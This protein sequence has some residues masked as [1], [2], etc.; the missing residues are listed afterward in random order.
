MVLLAEELNVRE[1]HHLLLFNPKLLAEELRAR[2]KTL[3]LL[4]IKKIAHLFLS[5]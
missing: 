3:I 2:Q 1:S 5:T 4:E